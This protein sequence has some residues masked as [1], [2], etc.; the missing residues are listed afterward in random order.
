M[1]EKLSEVRGEI[2]QQQGEFQALSK[3]IEM[4]TITIALRAE[5][6]TRVFGLNWRPLYQVK[7]AAR[8]GLEGLA[9][10]GAAMIA[11]VFYVPVILAWSA[12]ILLAVF[13]GWRLLRLVGKVFSWPKA[14]KAAV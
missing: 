7:V 13:V 3:Q 10:F 9:E 5:A 8:N 2:E 14:E 6:D 4:V 1:S 12:A 11:V